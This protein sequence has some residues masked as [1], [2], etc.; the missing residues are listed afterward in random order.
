MKVVLLLDR[1]NGLPVQRHIGN[2][3][4]LAP[5]ALSYSF[6]GASRGPGN[7]CDYSGGNANVLIYVLLLVSVSS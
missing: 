5:R 7:E 2:E 1:S 6:P 4:H 3:K